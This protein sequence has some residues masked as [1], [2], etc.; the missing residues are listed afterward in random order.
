MGDGEG[1]ESKRK[2]KMYKVNEPI[3]RLCLLVAALPGSPGQECP[4]RYRSIGS[5]R[6]VDGVTGLPDPSACRAFQ[7]CQVLTL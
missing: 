3:S 1:Q 6:Q 4:Q 2:V 5:S 7:L